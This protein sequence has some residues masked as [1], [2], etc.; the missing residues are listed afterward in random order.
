MEASSRKPMGF[1]FNPNH[2]FTLSP[3]NMSTSTPSSNARLV[4]VAITSSASYPSASTLTTPNASDASR[5]NANCGTR[6]SGH[7]P[8][9]ALYS[10]YASCRKFFPLK[11][12]A[13]TTRGRSPLSRRGRRRFWSIR[14]TPWRAPVGVPSVRWSGG[15]A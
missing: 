12:N 13:R 10:G 3:D 11:S 2:I 1:L 15:M 14:H 6:S 7:G 4:N 8:R 5:I 9:F